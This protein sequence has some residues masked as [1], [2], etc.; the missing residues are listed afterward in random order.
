MASPALAPPSLPVAELPPEPVPAP[1][2]SAGGREVVY[3]AL[4]TLAANPLTLAGFVLVVLLVVVAA[5]LLVIPPITSFVLGH[6]YTLLPYGPNGIGTDTNVGPTW[7]TWPLKFPPNLAHLLGTDELGRDIFS[8][9]LAALPLDLGIGMFITFLSV[10]I[11][12]ALGL[13]AG[14]WDEGRVGRGVSTVILRVTDI[15]LAFPSLVLA[16]A[17]AAILGRNLNATLIALTATWWPYYVR[18]VRGE[19]LVIKHQGYISAARIAGVSEPRIVLRHV[20]RNLLEPLTVYATLDIGSVIVTFS[21]I[22]FVGIAVPPNIPEWGSMVAYYQG[23]FYPSYLWLVF[24]PGAAIFVTVLGF[25][26]LGD[27]LRDVL[28]PRTRRAFAR[29]AQSS[30]LPE[31]SPPPL[32]LAEEE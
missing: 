25:S 17:L 20:L 27:G 21:T 13:V 14:F 29:E 9:V 28:D 22:A 15:F 31:P 23:S 24:A 1:S 2:R 5:L 10:G 3:E 19:V 26:L 16:L 4:R 12:G 7:W 8:R 30:T 11:G 6:A 32:P 18:I